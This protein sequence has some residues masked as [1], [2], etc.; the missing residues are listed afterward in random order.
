MQWTLADGSSLPS[1]M[2][3]SGDTTLNGQPTDGVKG[4]FDVKV[5][6]TDIASA[7]HE[8]SFKVTVNSPP[9]VNEKFVDA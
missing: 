6:V 2:S 5:K 8:V 3:K 9:F 7:S 1:W 4:T